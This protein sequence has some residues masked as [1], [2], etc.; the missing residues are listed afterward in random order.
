[1]QEEWRQS[2]LKDADRVLDDTRNW[3]IM[4]LENI[5]SEGR[6]EFP[7]PQEKKSVFYSA[8]ASLPLLL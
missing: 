3:R 6:D 4:W 5:F 1:M 7:G 8:V 2:T